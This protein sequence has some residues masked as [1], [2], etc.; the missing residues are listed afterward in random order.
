MARKRFWA[1]IEW[2]ERVFKAR[3]IC[4]EERRGVRSPRAAVRPLAERR[5]RARPALPQVPAP[6]RPPLR[7]GA[8]APTAS[9]GPEAGPADAH[10]GPRPPARARAPAALAAHEDKFSLLAMSSGS[11]RQG[12]PNEGYLLGGT[13]TGR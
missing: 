4:N 2:V 8:A 5:A 9:V 1:D 3:V 13:G 11:E 12:C 6:T 10:A 7:P